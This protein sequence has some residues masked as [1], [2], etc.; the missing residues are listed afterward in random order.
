MPQ[1]G[2]ECSQCTTDQ[3]VCQ[4]SRQAIR[5]EE[6]MKRVELQ[7]RYDVFMSRKIQII[8]TKSK[9]IQFRVSY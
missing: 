5:K 1:P 2:N 7:E 3:L 6:V 4:P 9:N 8:R